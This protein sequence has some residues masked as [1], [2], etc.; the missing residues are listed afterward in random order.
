MN[1][2][3]WEYPPPGNTGRT[4]EKGWFLPIKDKLDRHPGRWARIREYSSLT[5]ASATASR[6][7]NGRT[8]GAER[9]EAVARTV[10]GQHFVYARNRKP[11]E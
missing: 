8:R 1:V 3:R 2:F 10:N 7:S 11:G 9:I 6:L 5:S 4:G